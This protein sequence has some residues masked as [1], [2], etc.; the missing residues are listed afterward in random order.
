MSI[1]LSRHALVRLITTSCLLLR[2]EKRTFKTQRAKLSIEKRP[3]F[4]QKMKKKK[5]EK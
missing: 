3:F 4:Y 1:V 2:A 5:K